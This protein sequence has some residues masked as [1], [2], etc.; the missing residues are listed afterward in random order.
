MSE[1]RIFLNFKHPFLCNEYNSIQI[2]GF[3]GLNTDKCFC[4]VANGQRYLD[5]GITTGSVLFCQ[6]SSP[7]KDKDLVVVEEDG[8]F[9]VYL[10]LKNRQ[11]SEVGTKRIL[12]NKS[13]AYAK[14]LGSFNFYQ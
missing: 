8:G 13:K 9:A 2:D 7:I 4:I 6:R 3:V 5:Y 14:V 11:I 1:E 10:Y 12:H